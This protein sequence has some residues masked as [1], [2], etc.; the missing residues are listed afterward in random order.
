VKSL[1][2]DSGIILEVNDSLP[3]VPFRARIFDLTTQQTLIWD[4]A[5][6]FRVP[7]QEDP[8]PTVSW[9]AKAGELA[10]AAAVPS[11][12]TGPLG[13]VQMIASNGDSKT[14]NL[15]DSSAANA[16]IPTQS[17]VLSNDGKSIVYVYQS[18]NFMK[19]QLLMGAVNGTTRKQ[20]DSGDIPNGAT[21]AWSPDGIKLAVFENTQENPFPLSIIRIFNLANGS[22]SII[23]Y[24]AHSN[25]DVTS[26]K[27]SSDSKFLGAIIEGQFYISDGQG[28][29]TPA[30][31]SPPSFLIDGYAWSPDSS[32]IVFFSSFLA[33]DLCPT[34]NPI[35]WLD[36]F[37]GGYPCET[38]ENIFISDLNGSS[39]QLLTKEPEPNWNGSQLLWIR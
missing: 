30:F 14:F 21:P 7:F 13:S 38:N 28:P 35:Y 22:S 36:Q 18:D 10:F 4:I 39:M 23:T 2:N 15:N 17:I 26:M 29:F 25:F 11:S 16:S 37:E 9:L 34:G 24:P 12:S 5:T 6:D 20:L 19:T 8:A 31:P 1:P 32:K 27:W 3:L 33:P